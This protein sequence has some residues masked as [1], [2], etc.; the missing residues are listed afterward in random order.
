MMRSEERLQNIKQKTFLF[1]VREPFLPIMGSLHYRIHNIILNL[2]RDLKVFIVPSNQ[3]VQVIKDSYPNSLI[4]KTHVPILRFSHSSKFLLAT[5]FSIETFF[6]LKKIIKRYNVKAIYAFGPL[7]LIDLRYN[8]LDIPCFLDLTEVDLPYIRLSEHRILSDVVGLPIE[9]SLLSCAEKTNTKFIV[10]TETM[11]KY[12]IKRGIRTDNLLVAY[13]GTNPDLFSPIDYSKKQNKS[14]VFIGDIDNRDGIDILL[15]AFSY[16][17]KELNETKLFIIGNGPALQKMIKLCSKLQLCRH[18]VFTG[19]MSFSQLIRIL[20]TFSIGVV[21]SKKILLNEMI[22][23]RKTFEY[24]A[25]GLPVVAS[26]LAAMREVIKDNFSGVFFS[27]DDEVD[28]S[29][30]LIDLLTNE[31]LYTKIQRNGI[32]VAKQYSVKREV[33]KILTRITSSIN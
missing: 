11:K 17:V 7:I 20:P 9:N 18:V 2:N 12:L 22:I 29:E 14:I 5:M 16:V 1:Y 21:P 32:K 23:P 15:R 8:H 33:N 6:Q 10:L 28:L 13:D 26:D 3:D 4:Y 27:P 24:M 19:W 25:A 31:E 30:K